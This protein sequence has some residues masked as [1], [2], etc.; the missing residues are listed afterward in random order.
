MLGTATDVTARKRV[1]E[2]LARSEAFARSVVESSAD[3]VKG[4]TLDGKLLWMNENGKRLMEICDF[5]SV[6]GCD[7]ASFWDDAGLR[8][9][10][11]AALAAARAGRIGRFRGF[12][13]TFAGTPRW[14]DV[15]ITAV[16][17]PD[18]MPEQLLVV[19]RDIT[20]AREAEE[21][22]RKSEE[23]LT[24]AQRAGQ[25]RDLGL[26]RRHRRSE[27]DRGVVAVVRPP[28]V[29]KARHSRASGWK[30]STLMTGTRWSRRSR[31]RTRAE[32]TPPST[33]CGT[34]TGPSG[35]SSPGVRPSSHRTV[36]R[37][38]CSA[39]PAM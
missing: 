18:G 28:A 5:A 1:E 8:A 26:E 9:E 13:T 22:V 15:A 3:C 14:W 34:P 10:A 35:G 32:N 36:D 16:P 4:L 6:K 17:G 29:L 39:P 24:R 19:S 27:L 31:R 33:G 11:E 23:L 2:E 30:A 20:D 7:W 21:A 38:G 25:G 12:R 37:S